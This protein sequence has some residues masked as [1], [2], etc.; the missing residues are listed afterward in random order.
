M[1]GVPWFRAVRIPCIIAVALL[2][3]CTF[4]RPPQDAPD[5]QVADAAIAT[6][7][8]VATDH[9]FA[10][11]ERMPALVH[12]RMEN[13]GREVHHAQLLQLRDGRTLDDLFAVMATVGTP[14]F[15]MPDFVSWA[16][17]P[18]VIAPGQATTVTMRLRPGTYYWLCFI[19][20]PDDGAPHFA[21]GMLREVV[22]EPA[23]GALPAPSLGVML[24]DYDFQFTTEPTAGRHTVRAVNHAPQPHEIVIFRYLPGKTRA[25]VMAWIEAHMMGEPP[26]VPVGGVQAL[27]DG[28]AAN[29]DIELEPGD[30]VAICFIPDAAG[31]AP[32]VA[33]GMIRDFT[34]AS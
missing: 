27:D 20:S 33:H 17:G 7:T 12:V 3:A 11:P 34:I 9:E 13:H 6:I 30:Y 22:V 1:T 5:A 8:I 29:F 23:E 26:V 25:D 14:D 32:H 18:T 19:P 31:G 16:G 15:Q 2:A 10:A 21:K 28:M 24:T 4:D